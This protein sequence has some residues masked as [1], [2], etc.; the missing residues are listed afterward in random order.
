MQFFA[1]LFFPEFRSTAFFAD[2]IYNHKSIF[3]HFEER[4]RDTHFAMLMIFL[5]KS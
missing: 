5:I 4:K 3:L 2:M 1:T